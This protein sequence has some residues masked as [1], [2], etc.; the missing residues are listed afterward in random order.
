MGGPQSGLGAAKKQGPA[1]RKSRCSLRNPTGD[2]VG[3]QEGWP[4]LSPDSG[5]PQAPGSTS[6]PLSNPPPQ[7]AYCTPEQHTQP[8]NGRSISPGG[9]QEPRHLLLVPALHAPLAWPTASPAHTLSLWEFLSAAQHPA[10]WST[11]SPAQKGASYCISAW[12][13]CWGR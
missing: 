7:Q 2:K 11:A 1:Y 9:A 10:V 6:P 8:P 4:M 13:G 5:A 12:S 3:R